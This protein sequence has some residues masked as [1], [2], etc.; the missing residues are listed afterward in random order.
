MTAR[1]QNALL[2]NNYSFMLQPIFSRDGSINKYES[3]V[4][5]D[6]SKSE[7]LLPVDFFHE[8]EK[9]ESFKDILI[10]ST[11]NTIEFLKINPSA[12]VAINISYKDI[13]H[14]DTMNEF[15][16]V[17]KDEDDKVV[18]RI[19]IELIESFDIGNIE[20][21]VGFCKRLKERDIKISIDDFGIKNSNFYI[22]SIIDIDYLKIDGHF[23]KNISREK[24]RFIVETIIGLCKKVVLK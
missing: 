21:V 5:L 11:Q 2:E 20:K 19:I 15:M 22:L 13:E 16:N 4:R 6:I 7:K 14:D 18:E 23:I 17:I 10:A 8:A 9:N 1:I 3:L 24:T 12:K